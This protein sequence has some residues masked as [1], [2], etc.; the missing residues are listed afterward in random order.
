MAPDSIHGT[1]TGFRARRLASVCGLL[2]SICATCVCASSTSHGAPSTRHKPRAASIADKTRDVFVAPAGR[3]V[4]ATPDRMLDLAAAHVERGGAEG[5]AGAAVVAMLVPRVP[6]TRASELLSKL[7]APSD[8][9]LRDE[10]RW[11]AAALATERA[12][13]APAGLIRAWSIVGPF[14]DTGDGL[15]RREGPEEG[16]FADTS[17]TFDRGAYQVRWRPV[18]AALSTAAGI[19]LDVMISPRQESCSYLAS[20]FESASPETFVVHA[21]SSGSIRL[22]VDGEDG[23]EDEEIHRSLGFDR[24]ALKVQAQAGQHVLGVKVCSGSVDDE[25]RVRVRVTDEQGNARELKWSADLKPA[26]AG[27]GGA[28]LTVVRTPLQD[29]L[30]VEDK[31]SAER[32]LHAAVV[33]TLG[34]AEDERT[35]RAPGLLDRVARDPRM[36]ADQMALAA[37]ATP[38]GA[39]RSGRLNAARAK[40]VKANDVETQGFALRRLAALRVESGYPDWAMAALQAEPLASATDDE[41]RVLRAA[42][43]GAYRPMR[44]A[45]T[46]ELETIAQSAPETPVIWGLLAD[47]AGATDRELAAKAHETLYRIAVGASCAEVVRSMAAR[48]GDAVAKWASRC[49]EEGVQDAYELVVIGRA[50]LDA[51]KLGEAREHFRG[52]VELAPNVSELWSGLSLAAFASGRKE[53]LELAQRALERSRALDPGDVRLGAEARLR[54][55][56]SEGDDRHLVE[57]PVF[58]G[59]KA[60]VPVRE[61]EEADR[62]LYWKRAVQYLADHRVMQT[63]QYAR[64]VII[65]PRSQ[66][67]LME[68]LP[69]LEGDTVEVLRARIH[70]AGGG[71]AFAE[72]QASEGG[73]PRVRWPRL[74]KGDVVEVALRTHTAGPVGRRGDPPFF[75]MDHGGSIETHPLLYNEVVVETPVGQPLAVDVLHGDPDER[76]EQERDG[77]HVTRMVWTRPRNVPD[78]PLAPHPTET[79]PLVVGS[80]FPSWDAFLEWYRAAVKG[81]AEPDDQVKRLA[82]ELTR[83]ATTRQEKIERLFDYVADTIRYVNYVSG[84]FWLPNR[85]QQ[86]IAR[87]QGDCDDKAILLISL[88][89]AVGIEAREVLVQTRMT[90]QPSVLGSQRAAVPLFDHGIAYLPGKDGRPAMWLDAT[91]P[92]SRLGPLPSM[93]ARAMALFVKDGAAEVVAMPT[94]A[95]SDHGVRGVWKLELDASGGGILSAEERHAGDHGFE[96][97]TNLQEEASRAQWVEGNLLSGWFSGMRLEGKV[98]FEPNI[99]MGTAKVTYRAH[100]DG[101][102]RREGEDWVVPLAPS[103]TMT[104]QIAPLVSRKLPV[105][106]PPFLAPALQERTLRIVAPAGYRPGPLPPGGEENGGEFG[107][108]RLQVS[109]EPGHPDVV[110]VTRSVALDL[111]TIPVERYTAWRSWLQRVD[112][113]M[114]RGVRFIPSKT[115]PATSRGR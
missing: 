103:S 113:L 10:V 112:A 115:R 30:D 35:P 23:V 76:T 26:Q 80:T 25:G 52:S 102:A 2:A 83:G 39:D 73:R 18:P 79:I 53:E 51:G 33:R 57:A 75:F 22:M 11:M 13:K 100:S 14:E 6:L 94:S 31:A 38:F 109:L 114:H 74:E 99:G 69:S 29:A 42:A 21:A 68:N 55:R 98:G 60:R 62:E 47:Q 12:A 1:D 90:S 67:D 95:P 106:L 20:R 4:A 5:L 59:I 85:P 8:S 24:V 44:A 3:W 101:L 63:V 87:K 64:E 50:L 34:G 105:V 49:S 86:V 37:I 71:V 72:E 91:S 66:A 41:A 111:S 89:A 65:A 107:V 54:A 84:E 27:L 97:R 110:L 45:S 7:R 61:G 82:A 108:A 78:E 46:K 32:S 9:R 81:F 58:L 28:Q 16:S 96:L 56:K 19:P 93:D 104:S 43:L 17:R 36:S 15:R 48:G 92:Q 77:T 40:A 88:L 70:R